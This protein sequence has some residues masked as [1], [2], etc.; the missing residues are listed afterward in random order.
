MNVITV[1]GQL[2]KDAE[3]RYLPNG[4]AV[5]NFS[6]ADSQGREKP[7]IWWR[8]SLFGKRAESL[9]QYLK[10]GTSVTVSGTIT[11]R[12]YTDKDGTQKKAME[13]RA[14]DVALQ[15]G[16][17]DDAQQYSAPAQPARPSAPQQRQAPPR[18]SA[19]PV[20]SGFDDMSDDIPFISCDWALEVETS[21][22][23]RMR[24]YDF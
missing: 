18:Q 7:T 22:A 4:D 2:G 1:A 17:R 19:P 21:K 10:K 11:E 13:V 20:S 14:N 5:C 3:L 23:K 8:A 24:R 9:S 15:G 12:E 6:V 16:K